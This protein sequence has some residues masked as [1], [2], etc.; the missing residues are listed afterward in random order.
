MRLPGGL[1]TA[2]VC[3]VLLLQ[4]VLAL[5]LVVGQAPGLPSGK[6]GN[7]SGCPTISTRLRCSTPGKAEREREDFVA[8]SIQ[9]TKTRPEVPYRATAVQRLATNAGQRILPEQE[10][11]RCRTS[12]HRVPNLWF[13]RKQERARPCNTAPGRIVP[14]VSQAWNGT[15][16]RIAP[17]RFPVRPPR[18]CNDSKPQSTSR[19]LWQQSHGGKSRSRPSNSF[20]DASTQIFSSESMMGAIG[21]EGILSGGTTSG[22]GPVEADEISGCSTRVAISIAVKSK[23]PARK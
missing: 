17:C 20:R 5:G 8:R 16:T 23:A 15:G 12:H 14:F 1:P 6:H 19:S 10:N 9:Q 21:P 2:Q 13:S 18:K 7:R 11:P 22:T 3:S 4:Y